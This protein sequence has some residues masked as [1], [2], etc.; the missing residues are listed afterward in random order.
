MGIQL[1][2]SAVLHSISREWQTAILEHIGGEGPPE[3]YALGGGVALSQRSCE[4]TRPIAQREISRI[5][6]HSLWCQNAMAMSYYSSALVVKRLQ[7]G[8]FG[9]FIKPGYLLLLVKV[10][11]NDLLGFRTSN[12]AKRYEQRGGLINYRLLLRDCHECFSP[13]PASAKVQRGGECL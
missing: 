11:R 12:N 8:G 1:Y 2:W 6:R 3:A 4:R 13:L 7:L 5:G 10:A 9:S